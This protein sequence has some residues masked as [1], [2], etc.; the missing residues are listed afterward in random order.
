MESTW[1]TK[2]LTNL[3][4]ID[5]QSANETLATAFLFDTLVV[6]VVIMCVGSSTCVYVKY[7][8]KKNVESREPGMGQEDMIG[9]EMHLYVGDR[10]Q[11]RNHMENLN[12]NPKLP[13]I[14]KVEDPDSES[15]EPSEVY[16]QVQAPKSPS[17]VAAALLT[18]SNTLEVGDV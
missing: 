13:I 16:I 11:E 10:N 14:I 8:R 12:K 4:D 1:T 15:G 18:D 17:K 2:T 9:P 5:N 3:A 7:R 6:T